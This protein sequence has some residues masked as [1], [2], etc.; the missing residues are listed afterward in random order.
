MAAAKS[1]LFQADI[2]TGLS[3][4]LRG[5]RKA[6]KPPAW[7]ALQKRLSTSTN[8][9]LRDRVRDLSALFG[10]GRALDEVRRLAQD[11]D[12]LLGVISHYLQN[13][14]AGMEMSAQRLHDRAR[15]VQ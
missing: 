7:E 5:W 4:A 2:L 14:L 9:A 1:E 10:D 8:S 13:H 11:K 6:Q 15:R 3:E 12:E